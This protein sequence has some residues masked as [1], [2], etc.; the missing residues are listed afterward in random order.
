MIGKQQ[1]PCCMWRSSMLAVQQY[2]MKAGLR[3]LREELFIEVV[4]HADEPLVILNYDQL[5]SP[6]TDP[7]V[8]QCRGLTLEKD[9][10]RVVAKAFDRFINWGELAHEQQ[11]F[12]WSRFQCQTK[13]DGSLI[14]LYHYRGKWRVNTRGSFGQD[15]IHGTCMTWHDLVWE[16]IAD[17]TRLDPSLTY[18]CEVVSPYT[19]VVRRY[20]QP[21]LYLL[22]SFT[23]DPE[24]PQELPDEITQACAVRLGLPRPEQHAFHSVTAIQEWLRQQEVR[25]PSFEG[26]VVRDRHNHRWKIKNRSYLSFHGFKHDPDALTNPRY[27]L[28]FILNG[29]DAELL[30]YYPEVAGP[31]RRLKQ[32]VEAEFG[33][34]RALWLQTR[35]ISDQKAFAQAIQKQSSFTGVLFTLRK[36]PL[37]QQTEAALRQLWRQS[38]LQILNWI[39]PKAARLFGDDPEKGAC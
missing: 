39:K 21:Q 32:A 19:Q 34:L 13:E 26:V 17:P 23:N 38:E 30:T 35:D 10:W 20:A 18:V 16:R 29:E 1:M 7:I 31:Y 8:R 28:P 22:T 33:R 15:S 14:L 5:N 25:D 9:S 2:L 6:R 11:H 12:D 36:Q 37:E 4:E 3:Q 24:R 27:L